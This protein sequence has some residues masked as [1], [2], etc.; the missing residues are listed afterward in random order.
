VQ[1]YPPIL[2][3][4]DDETDAMILRM[5]A[6]RAGLP[7]ELVIVPDGMQAIAYLEGAPPYDDRSQHP[8]PGVLLLDLKMPYMTGFEVLSW[9]STRPELGGL[10]AVILSSS[11]QDTDI[12]RARE[13]GA[14]DYH[15]KPHSL[16]E[17]IGILKSIEERWLSCKRTSPPGHK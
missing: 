1:E 5:A 16:A 2:V 4:E 17:L 11:S 13:L 14:S 12:A 10:P 8:L 7:Y 3:A 6:E 15:V 9:L